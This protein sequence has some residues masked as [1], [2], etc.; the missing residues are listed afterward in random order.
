M[1]KFNQFEIHHGLQRVR[2]A[3]G[4]LT[5]GYLNMK[6]SDKIS[7]HCAAVIPILLYVLRCGLL[8]AE[9]QGIG[10]RKLIKEKSMIFGR[11]IIFDQSNG[12]I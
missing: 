11:E 8:A 4:L 7:V 1:I 9:P 5:K 12:V 3:F 2:K 6:T 10:K